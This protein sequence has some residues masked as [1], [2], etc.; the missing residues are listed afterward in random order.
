VKRTGPLSQNN[1][2]SIMGL[3][4]KRKVT[5]EVKQNRPIK[6]YK[7]NFLRKQENQG[8]PERRSSPRGEPVGSA[9]REKKLPPL[10]RSRSRGRE[11]RTPE[12]KS[13]LKKSLSHKFTKDLHFRRFKASGAK[14]KGFDGGIKN[15]ST[16]L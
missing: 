6:F 2:K 10:I 1:N 4:E 13:I 12:I 16:G 3:P 8:A 5:P 9:R 11:T 15:C 14:Y 7:G